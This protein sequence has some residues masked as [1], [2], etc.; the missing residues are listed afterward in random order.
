MLKN[1]DKVKK[2][3]KARADSGTWTRLLNDMGLLEE[4]SPVGYL[5]IRAVAM[6]HNT[7]RNMK[8][9]KDMNFPEQEEWSRA[10]HLRLIRKLFSS[11]MTGCLEVACRSN[12]I[13]VRRGG[14]CSRAVSI[15]C[16]W[17][18]LAA[19]GLSKGRLIRCRAGGWK[20]EFIV[21]LSIHAECGLFIVSVKGVR[22]KE[23]FYR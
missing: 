17:S 5:T 10:Q 18:P 8:T 11:S 6:G 16:M 22:E 19:P 23:S 1:R 20:A 12:G 15:R 7:V 14:L 9:K 4:S 2:P 3:I 21:I 13:A